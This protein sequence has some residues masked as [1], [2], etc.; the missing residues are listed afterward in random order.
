[1]NNLS[2]NPSAVQ[3][4]LPNGAFHTVTMQYNPQNFTYTVTNLT[5][6]GGSN[7][8]SAPTMMA[9]QLTVGGTTWTIQ[10]QIHIVT[11]SMKGRGP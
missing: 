3:V 4:T 7:T 1:M 5:G 10:S 2:I 6:A 8:F 11:G 9:G